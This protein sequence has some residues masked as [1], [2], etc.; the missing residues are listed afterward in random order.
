MKK[1]VLILA[2]VGILSQYVSGQISEG[3]TPVSF[4]LNME[5]EKIPLIEMPSVNAKALIEEDE[6]VRTEDAQR[7]FRF[8]YAH[9]V[10][11][12]LKKAGTKKEA[13]D[14]G[15]IWLLK[16]HCPD[17]FSINLIYDRFILGKGSKFFI[18]SEDR[19]MLMGAFTPE[20]SNNQYNEFAT[21]LVQGNTIVLEYYEPVSSGDGV[22][23]ISKVIH[24]YM[25]TFFS[26]G[27]G[28]SANCNIDVICPQWN[29]WI[30][31]RR[32][33]TLILVDNNTAWCS[34]CLVNNT[35]QDFTPYILTARHCYFDQNGNTQTNFP[36]TN[37][38]RFQYWRPNC[39]S[40]NPITSRS[41]TGATLR[42]HWATTD[43]ALLQLNTRLPADWDVFYA[44]WD[45]TATPAQTATGIHHPR[46]DAMKISQERDAVFAQ[47]HPIQ[48]HALSTWRVQHFEDGTVQP[49]SSGSP[50]FNQNN[51]IVGQLSTSTN[52]GNDNTC[53]CNNRN[54]NYGRFD[55]SWAGGGTNATRL[56]N[57][58]APGMSSPPQTLDG[59][60][61]PPYITGP[62]VVGSTGS[63]T[64]INPP[65]GTIYWTVSNTSLYSV[66]SSGN[67]VTVTSLKD[68]VTD[69]ATVSVM[70]HAR[71]GSVSG[72][73]ISSKE[74]LPP[75]S[76]PGGLC[77]EDISYKLNLPV[78]GTV[79]WTVSHSGYPG[80]FT[81]DAQGNPT[82]VSHA[83][84]GAISSILL[85]A[86]T[87][88]ISGPVVATRT[89]VTCPTLLTGPPCIAKGGTVT[90]Y[91]INSPS[92]PVNWSVGGNYF[93]L[94]SSTGNSV[95]VSASSS[96]IEGSSGAVIAVFANGNTALAYIQ[97]CG[98]RSGGD[99]D[100]ISV[101][102][103][104][105][106]DILTVEIDAD[107]ILS[108]LTERANLTFDVR[109]YNLTG[110]PVQQT[111][112]KG[113][114]IQFN[115]S[116]LPNGFY[117]LLVSDNVS[118]MSKMQT[119]IVQH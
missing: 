61:H 28:T 112:T 38:F 72:P 110:T 89:I 101:Y 91:L 86:R 40:S 30:N 43:F 117:Y 14:G 64:L 79:F 77:C 37:I 83:D 2:V 27:L 31:E 55:L 62:N 105:V 4:S 1:I 87:G 97:V 11:I 19:K 32:S 46:G 108:Q 92:A 29:A 23:C 65:P 8:G 52:C 50:L 81:V 26:N 12:D 90:Y 5:K 9:D 17:A 66:T 44:G 35:E 20:V 33:V 107:V 116:N 80:A 115:V 36:A 49:G 15:N 85:S 69:P 41:I 113:G 56:S 10:D 22:I 111:T 25:D 70:L 78:S 47:N 109:L 94:V 100:Y 39:G 57:W 63:F 119:V 6:K 3:G 34:G 58:L 95:T 114:K 76:G 54:G 53:A 106:S 118:N 24:G 104:P 98:G 68:P 84:G 45:R 99:P 73:I 18:Y 74:I 67:P 7:P 71:T 42:A 96:A 51:R 60:I 75:V 88:S 59:I 103:N 16:I 21:D 13:P 102:P 82:T 48:G 93:S